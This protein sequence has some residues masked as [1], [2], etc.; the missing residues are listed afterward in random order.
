MLATFFTADLFAEVS[1]FY[2]VTVGIRL[3]LQVFM[4]KQNCSTARKLKYE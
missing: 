2:I 3:L 1:L 4:T